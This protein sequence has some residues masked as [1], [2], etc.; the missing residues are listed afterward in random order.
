MNPYLAAAEMV[1]NGVTYFSCTSISRVGKSHI[2]YEQMFA[3]LGYVPTSFW[4]ERADFSGLLEDCSKREW[5]LTALYL[6]AA[7]YESGDIE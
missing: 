4:L 1:F 3:P 6:A 5:R 2:H 7:M